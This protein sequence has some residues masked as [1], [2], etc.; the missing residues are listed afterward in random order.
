MCVKRGGGGVRQGGDRPENHRELLLLL[1]QPARSV[2]R[3]GRKC[4]IWKIKAR[5][6]KRETQRDSNGTNNVHWESKGQVSCQEAHVGD[7]ADRK[8]NKLR[9][10]RNVTDSHKTKAEPQGAALWP[11]IQNAYSTRYS[12]AVSHPSTNQALPCLASEIRRDR[13]HSRWYG[14]RRKPGSH[15][16]LLS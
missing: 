10:V 13:A 3:G 5:R 9:W 11:A 16:H 12:Q 7:K 15:F 6:Q 1:L 4:G 2:A 8:K 14:R